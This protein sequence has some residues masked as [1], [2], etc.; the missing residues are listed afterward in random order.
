MHS[1]D[2]PPRD[3][4]VTNNGDVHSPSSPSLVSKPP[5][6]EVTQQVNNYTVMTSVNYI[7]QA[8]V[9]WS[10]ES[11]EDLTSKNELLGV[12]VASLT[13][14]SSSSKHNALS[15]QPTQP[16]QRAPKLLIGMSTIW[17]I[18]FT[19]P[20]RM[21]VVSRGGSKSGDILKMLKE[22]KPSSYEDITILCCYQWLYHE[23][24]SWQDMCQF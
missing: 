22:M 4:T 15:T 21:Y 18:A 16:T 11:I 23:I 6:D 13:T 1:A 10:G 7:I 8:R 9:I 19:D 17:N 3:T 14:E 20:K 24:S 12:Q 5:T 2:D